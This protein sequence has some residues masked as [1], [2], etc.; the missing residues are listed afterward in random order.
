MNT[1]DVYYFNTLREWDGRTDTYTNRQTD[2]IDTANVRILFGN[3][4]ER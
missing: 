4:P 2:R 1:F 3:K